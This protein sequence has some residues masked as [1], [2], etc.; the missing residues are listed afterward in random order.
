[1]NE[2]TGNL[3]Y[4][5]LQDSAARELIR[6]IR[7]SRLED[8]NELN[9]L[10]HPAAAPA[11]TGGRPVT[12]EVLAALRDQISELAVDFAF[13]TPLS[14]SKQAEFDRICGTLL[15][16][17]MSIVPGD[18]ANSGVWSF[19]TL[20]LLPSIAPWRFRSPSDE[21]LIGGSR[22]AFQ[23]L[24]WRAWSLGPDLTYVAPGALALG[25]DDYVQITERTTLGGNRRL[26]QTVQAAVWEFDHTSIGVTRSVLVRALAKRVLA[27]KAHTTFDV[28]DDDDLLEAV[29]RIRDDAIDYAKTDPPLQA[30]DSVVG[31]RENARAASD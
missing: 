19:I 23:R 26:A 2:Y 20:V 16:R 14:Q 1:M 9:A 21:R 27:E 12:S 6:T 15:F 25:E 17:S 29:R 3:L 5:R 28:F 7:A 11:A 24:W 4:P 13:P 31:S 10:S 8:L 22:N 30:P 18:A